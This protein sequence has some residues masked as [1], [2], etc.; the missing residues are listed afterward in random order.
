MNGSHT[1]VVHLVHVFHIET[2]MELTLASNLFVHVL[3]IGLVVVLCTIRSF[4]LLP[5]HHIEV[6]DLVVK[7]VSNFYL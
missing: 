5:E 7:H 3:V 4:L 6:R 1:I 2:Y